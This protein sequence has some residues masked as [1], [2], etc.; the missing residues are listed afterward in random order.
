MVES[1]TGLSEIIGAA[2]S[3]LEQACNTFLLFTANPRFLLLVSGS[4]S[5]L[6]NL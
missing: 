1:N 2:L 3:L 6:N 5:S 4:P